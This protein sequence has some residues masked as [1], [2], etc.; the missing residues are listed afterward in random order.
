MALQ[1][2]AGKLFSERVL[3]L[4][5]AQPHPGTK[6]DETVCCAG[7]TASGEWRRQY[8][9]HF[10]RT[11]ATFARWDW[12]KYECIIPKDDR[13]PE[14]RRVQED[15]IK[16]DGRMSKKEQARF[17]DRIAVE[18]TEAA[19]AAGRTLALIRPT[20]SRFSWARKSDTRVE[21]ERKANE[22]AAR[23]KTFFD[24]DIVA[25]DPC[26]FEFRFKYDT[27]DGRSHDSKC[28]DWETSAM[29]FNLQHSFGESGA[30]Q[31]MNTVF[32]DEYPRNGMMFALG[33]H[34]RFP[35]SWLL[36]G[37]IRADK[38]EQPELAL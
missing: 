30:L 21:S 7:V 33:T 16:V 6:S 25:L 4:V 32:N 19:A 17:L 23:Q 26:P 12:I 1:A 13:R 27:Q 2:Q 20:N 8:P 28:G 29:F 18:S 37:V 3:V 15:T 9:I 34:S 24:H 31:R 10:R 14:S 38:I 5:K 22:D 11:N 35:E 36:V